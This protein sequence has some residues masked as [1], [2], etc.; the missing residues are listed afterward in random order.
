MYKAIIF[1][2]DGL[3]IDSEVISYKLYQDLIRPYGYSFSIEDYANNYSGKTALGNMQAIIQRFQLSITVNQGLEFIA[4]HEKKYFEKG[5]ALKTGVKELLE[6]LKKN[7]YKIVLASSS[8]KERAMMVLKQHQIEL[9]FDEMVFGTE[10]KN[11]KPH[12]DIFIKACQKAHVNAQEALVLE[13]S[14]A[15]IKAA[16]LADIPVICIPDMRAPLESFQKMTIRIFPN[17]LDVITYLNEN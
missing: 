3:L 2:L 13:D 10:V 9:Y 8:I 11:G 4:K 16:Y 1:D 5:V 15:G 14:E 17:L 6:Y 12:P 7:H